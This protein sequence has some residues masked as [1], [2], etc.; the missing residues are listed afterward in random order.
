MVFLPV[1]AVSVGMLVLDNE[2]ANIVV[3]LLEE[4][5][6]ANNSR[7]PFSEGFAESRVIAASVAFSGAVFTN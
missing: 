1:L 3:A 7:V 6:A 2:L 4:R 5:N